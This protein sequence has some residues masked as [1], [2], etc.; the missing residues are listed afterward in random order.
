[1]GVSSTPVREAFR[2]LEAERL[3]EI[4]PHRGAVVTRLSRQE[5]EEI[6]L[7]R[8]R[9]EPL[10]AAR[11]AEWASND[12]IAD[13]RSLLDRLEATSPQDDR[14]RLLELNK[15]FHFMIYQ[16]SGLPRLVG[17]IESLWAPVEAVRAA[18]VSIPLMARKAAT[19][20]GELFDAIRKRQPQVAA[21]ITAAHLS[22]TA[23]V[24]LERIES[25]EDGVEPI[26][27][28]P[29]VSGRE[30][31]REAEPASRRKED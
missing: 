11:A 14:S 18:Y 10:A 7:I 22:A 1:M 15:R 25:A 28:Q 8:G 23:R 27:P 31:L 9:L 16:A 6:Y 26:Q 24:L 5:I 2:Q 3:I 30:E 13:I 21:R 4:I 29:V 17:I 20:H 19:E 12:A